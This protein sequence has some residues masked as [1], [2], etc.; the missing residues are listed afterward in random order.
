MKKLLIIILLLFS[1]NAFGQV[2]F[3]GTR[4]P[5]YDTGADS[6]ITRMETATGKTMTVAGKTMISDMFKMYKDS[7]SITSLQ[8]FFDVLYFL[9]IGV[10]TA[11]K[12]NWVKDAH[13]ITNVNSVVF[14]TVGATG[15][16]TNSH[17]NTN[18]N[19][20]TDNVNFALNSSSGAVYCKTNIAESDRGLMGNLGYDIE[21]NIQSTSAFYSRICGSAN[22]MSWDY[23]ST[24]LIGLHTAVRTDTLNT[25]AYYN[26]DNKD[27]KTDYASKARTNSVVG[28]CIQFLDYGRSTNTVSFAYL[29]KTIDVT[30]LR[31]IYNILKYWQNNKNSIT[32]FNP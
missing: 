8:N 14:D 23:T 1:F 27:S 22:I 12:L 31:K 15:N 16:G 3:S 4:Q 13:N 24:G 30:Q 26:L 19:M 29:G 10:E 11:G 18:Y 25:I 32:F 20:S 21:F 2:Y 17:L 9:D 7:L 28:I 5:L 6:L